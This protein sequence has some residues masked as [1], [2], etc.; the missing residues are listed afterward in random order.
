MQLLLSA[1]AP[2]EV[3]SP[4]MTNPSQLAASPHTTTEHPGLFTATRAWKAD[5]RTPHASNSHTTP[6]DAPMHTAPFT[7]TINQ[8]PEI[9]HHDQM[10][11][12]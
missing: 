6:N 12:T 2:N 8:P 4:S 11:R 9:A 10:S 1:T 5:R 7:A 3:S